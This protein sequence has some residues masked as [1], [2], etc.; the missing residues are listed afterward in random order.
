M[1]LAVPGRIISIQDD[2]ARVDIKGVMIQAK[3]MLL[4]NLRVGD[5]VIVHAGFA[6]QKYD[7]RDAEETLRLLEE[8]EILD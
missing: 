3:T 1:C 5:Y 8:I 4:D 6:I 2:T 7:R